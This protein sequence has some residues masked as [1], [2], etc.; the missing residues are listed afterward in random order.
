M[1]KGFE[2][3]VTHDV[4]RIDN[5]ETIA[6]YKQAVAA[7]PEAILRIGSQGRHVADARVHPRDDWDEVILR[8]PHDA[9][10]EGRTR[11]VF[12]GRYASFYYW[13]YQ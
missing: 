2:T 4:A 5:P 3:F 9:L 10:G 6:K 1:R 12:T 7:F 8:I 13:F 11:L